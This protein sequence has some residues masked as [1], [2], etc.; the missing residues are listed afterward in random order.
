LGTVNDPGEDVGSAA[1][2]GHEIEETAASEGD[3]RSP[4][5]AAKGT[6]RESAGM[7]TRPGQSAEGKL[8]S[9]DTARNNPGDMVAVCGGG[10]IAEEAGGLI[11]SL[12]G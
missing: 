10:F 11:G 3:L 12:P 1:T 8:V 6:D 5:E 4:V 9:A 7:A 2:K